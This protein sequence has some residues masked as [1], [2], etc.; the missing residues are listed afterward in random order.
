MSVVMGEPRVKRGHQRGHPQAHDLS[1]GDA[2][3]PVSGGVRK[4][5]KPKEG[6]RSKTSAAQIQAMLAMDLG[7]LSGTLPP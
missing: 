4:G 5:P 2:A 3:Q 6:K 1:A 7:G